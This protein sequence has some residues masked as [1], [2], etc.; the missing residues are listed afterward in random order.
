MRIVDPHIP[1]LPVDFGDDRPELAE[2]LAYA[3]N[4][5][6]LNVFHVRLRWKAGHRDLT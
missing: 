2:C 6:S 4:I 5:R 1:E 3:R